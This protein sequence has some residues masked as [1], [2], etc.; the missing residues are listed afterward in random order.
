MPMPSGQ[1][2]IWAA[3]PELRTVSAIA[4]RIRDRFKVVL[5]SRSGWVAGRAGY[6]PAE[7]ALLI[8]PQVSTSAATTPLMLNTGSSKSPLQTVAGV[9]YPIVWT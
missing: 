7:Y 8:A 4:I 1:G 9:L 6:L 5:P 3:A 2:L